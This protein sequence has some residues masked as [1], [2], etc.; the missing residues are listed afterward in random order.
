MKILTVDF[1]THYDR[2]YSLLKMT[3]EEYVRS[4]KFEVIGVAVE[5]PPARYSP[6][7]TKLTALS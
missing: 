5:V 1:E 4:D 6:A 3:T 7:L 2:E